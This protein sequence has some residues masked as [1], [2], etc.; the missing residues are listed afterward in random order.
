MTIEQQKMMLN[1]IKL[2]NQ[3]MREVNDSD[4]ILDL[5]DEVDEAVDLQLEILE[6]AEEE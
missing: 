4:L 5:M 1:Y 6:D 3:Q 2:V